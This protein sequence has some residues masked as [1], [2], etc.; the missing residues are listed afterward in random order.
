MQSI[1]FLWQGLCFWALPISFAYQLMWAL[2]FSIV[3]ESLWRSVGYQ[4]L[5]AVKMSSEII[6]YLL[7]WL[8][9]Y[10]FCESSKRWAWRVLDLSFV[11]LLGFTVRALLQA[12]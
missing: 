3:G 11:F 7:L 4:N 10:R 9:L 2:A 12:L 6:L 8:G 5:L 1:R